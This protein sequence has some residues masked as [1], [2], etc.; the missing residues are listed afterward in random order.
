[1]VDINSPLDTAAGLTRPG[2]CFGVPDG[3]A[4]VGDDI[5]FAAAATVPLSSVRQ[6]R[7]ELAGPP[8]NS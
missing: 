3:L 7:N 4:I 8:A 5:D 6:R 1:V 2:L